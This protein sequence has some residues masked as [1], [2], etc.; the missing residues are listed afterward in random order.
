M[1]SLFSFSTSFL[2]K[3]IV[4]KETMQEPNLFAQSYTS[5]IEDFSNTTYRA[6]ATTA[7][8]WGTG[9]VTGERNF[10]WDWLDL[11]MTAN[12]I[13]DIAVQG[14][15]VF[16]A[17]YNPSLTTSTM[18]SFDINDPSNIIQLSDDD[19]TPGPYSV[20]VEGDVLYLGYAAGTI[21]VNTYNIS[22]PTLSSAAK[23]MDSTYA[24]GRVTDIEADGHLMYYASYDDSGSDSFRIIDASDPDVMVEISS[25]WV[26]DK[27]LGL[28]V[29][30]PI[31]YLAESDNG[32]YIVNTTVKTATV[33][34]GHIDTPGNATD[35]IVDGGFAYVADGPAG[36]QIVDIRDPT[37]PQIVGSYNTPGNARKLALQGNTLFVADGPGGVI[38]LD[39][40]DLSHPTFV[41]QEYPFPLGD[42]NDVDLFGGILVVGA[43]LGLY[44]YEIAAIGGGITDFSNSAYLNAYSGHK[45]YDV[46]VKGNIA[47]VAGG[48]DGLYTLNVRDPNNPILLDQVVEAPSR[49][50]RK[51]EVRGNF[52][53]VADY[54][55]GG[56]LRIYDISDPT[57][58]FQ[59]DASGL[60]YA[61]DVT[62]SGDFAFVADGS[63]GV[64]VFD[65]SNPYS[66]GGVINWWDDSFN[67]ITAVWVQGPHLYVVDHDAG[68][69]DNCFYVYNVKDVNDEKLTTVDDLTSYCYDVKV[70]GDI[71]YVA[72]QN[73]LVLY[74]VSDKY[75]YDYIHSADIGY[76]LDSYGVWNF[77]PYVMSAAG[78]E[79]IYLVNETD[80]SSVTAT[81]Y[82]D[83]SGA[84]QVTSSG[85]YTYVAN[86]TSLVILRHFESAGDTY[87]PIIRGAQSLELDS[88]DSLIL[89]ATLYADDFI[90]DGVSINYL[91]TADGFYWDPVTPNV[92]HEFT[93][94]GNDLRFRAEILG[95]TDRSPH[96]YEIAIQYYV[97]EAPSEPTITDPGDVST[98]SSVAVS[99]T[100]STDDDAIDHYELQVDTEIGFATPINSYNVSDLSRIV[101]GLS[102]GTYYFRVRAVDTYDVAST[103]SDVVDIEVEIP[104]LN[105]EWWHYV[106]V[107]GGLAAVILIIVIVVRVRKRKIVATR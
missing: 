87:V 51:L 14:R 36:V 35:V 96:L 72:D 91:M 39:L 11:E 1:V 98:S 79:G 77:G 23:Y 85:D 55:S 58:I 67:N 10:S 20:T 76:Y 86:T 100:A 33:E 16:A 70:D 83:A 61:A 99:W 49:F 90:P 107:F 62:L 9:G 22:N 41:T 26:S 8:G 4:A 84:I 3:S 17:C 75:S 82:P 105:L 59:T 101:T 7:D 89:R 34:I 69:N 60:T 37:N 30:Y 106:I 65:I 29:E 88:T 57:N 92:E 19:A 12:P 54:G 47:Y 40:A 71:A 81:L 52:A 63:F 53:Y 44:T 80:F 43:D 27:T 45:A 25:N 21:R 95:A 78:A 24:D 32:L 28:Y 93:H 68:V 94:I 31:A 56:G 50:Y 5:V 73:W 102:N 46:R 42:A 18:A 97:N 38:V 13:T 2:S 104:A 103:W 74:N 66:I 15:K 64:Y 6:G 48:D